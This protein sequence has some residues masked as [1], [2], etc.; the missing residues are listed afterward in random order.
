VGLFARLSVRGKINLGIAAIV[1]VS[2]LISAALVSRAALRAMSEE[3]RKRG[4]NLVRNLAT[5]AIEPTLGRNYLALGSIVGQTKSLD[6]SLDYVFLL[7]RDGAVLA[8]SFG[9][10]FPVELLGINPPAPS[11]E[12]SVKLVLAGGERIHDF[13]CAVRVGEVVIG[14]ARL[15]MSH[16][17][18]SAAAGELL[19][20]IG[21]I[22][23]ACTALALV[24]GS[25]FARRLSRRINSLRDSAERLV[26]G[27]LGITTVSPPK[28]RC[29]EL[30]GCKLTH[31]PAHGDDQC[32]CWL[33][34]GTV[35]AQDNHQ[36]DSCI[37]CPVYEANRGDELKDLA[38]VFDVMAFALKGHIDALT[39]KESILARQKRLLKTV[40]D[41]TPDMVSLRD[42]NLVY[43]AA[44]KAFCA[45]FGVRE[46]DVAGLAD[47]DFP[48]SP[49]TGEDGGE[50]K[51]VLSSRAP[52]TREVLVGGQ[53]SRKWF[54]VVKIPVECE[55]SRGEWGQG[56]L[57]SARDITEVKVFQEQLV[58]SQKMESLGL[59]AGGV[60]HEINTP[61]AIILGYAQVMQDDA[62]PE[63]LMSKALT[64]I[65]NN[66]KACRKI[67]ADLLDFSRKGEN[68]REPLDVNESIGEVVSFIRNIFLHERI[69][70]EFAPAGGLPP[71]LGDKARLR[72][73]WINLLNNARDAVAGGGLIAIRTGFDPGKQAVTVCVAD[74]GPGVAPQD[75][76]RLFDPFFS[77]KPVG[78]GTG[79]G[80]SVSFGI[81]ADH[82]GKIAAVSP[83]PGDF[84]ADPGGGPPG[85]ARG[86][87]ALFRVSLPAA[88]GALPG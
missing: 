54:H 15:G 45:Y 16:K 9:N 7:D 47:R 22:T 48:L 78:K 6:D 26:R 23:A 60:A 10:A 19:N 82:G 83:A 85:P 32:R 53:G 38:E 43:L 84:F 13:A 2:G 27:E 87:G 80:L 58:E 35:C 79:L 4:V 46:Q 55:D 59:L 75:L 17:A 76:E 41:V 24:A 11:G 34:S 66:A 49:M 63:S 72:Q 57:L 8:H 42:K 71:I 5:R 18:V 77:T 69:Q 36:A 33:T 12:T 40:F 64:L 88:P 29:W 73:V 30:F 3:S 50:D 68:L 61:L 31:C 28:T 14:A 86:P 67:V 1:I 44:N 65:E 81:V 25:V 56:L 62:P 21:A 52:L 70:V 39:E 20:L 37:K 74:T 51:A